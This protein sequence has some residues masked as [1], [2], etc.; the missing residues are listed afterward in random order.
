[1]KTLLTSIGAQRFLCSLTLGL[2]V[3]A[4]TRG[5][6]ADSTTKR[7]LGGGKTATDSAPEASPPVPVLEFENVTVDQQLG[8]AYRGALK[9]LLAV[10]TLPYDE[11]RY[12]RTGLLADPPGKFIRAGGNYPTPWTRDA[13]IN[14]WNAASLLEPTVARNT[15]WAVCERQENGKLIIQRDNQW[16]DKVIW[17]TG[18]WSHFKITADQEFLTAAYEAATESLA[19][20]K[21]TRFNEAYGLFEGPSVLCDGIAGYSQPPY[22][23]ENRSSFALNHPEVEKIMAF[24]TNCVYYNAYRCA[25]A[26]ARQMSRPAAEIQALEVSA[27]SLRGKIQQH[28]WI[29][30][31]QLYGYFIHG[32]GPLKGVLDRSEEGMGLAYSV[33]FGVAE[34]EGA[35]K[36]LRNTHLQPKGITCV[37]PHFKRFSDERPGRHNVMVWP[38]CSGMWAHAAAM[39]GRVDLFKREMTTIAEL[40][41]ASDGVFYEIYNSVSGAVDGGWQVGRHYSS[42]TEQTWSATGYLRMVFYGLFGMEFEV[43]GLRFSPCLPRE[44]GPVFLRGLRYRR[45]VLDILLDGAGTRVKS[46]K[47][48][49]LAVERPFVRADLEGLHRI[50]IEIVVE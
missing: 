48:D 18:A 20:M 38:M 19:E 44:W 7:P 29:P 28:F 9:N 14:C 3:L 49:G 4:V 35:Q 21:S 11:K 40:T 2:L 12:N 47:L 26:M 41:N 37:W 45:M 17:I 10:N 36:V 23:P 8:T 27:E 39:A 43:E 16:W 31:K 24:S 46:C 30:E 5:G 15:L 42:R 50:A 32:G 1:M 25:A 33:I 34:G 13:A 22:D 6:L